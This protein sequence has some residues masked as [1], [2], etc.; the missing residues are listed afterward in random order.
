MRQQLFQAMVQ[1]GFIRKLTTI[2]RELEN[3]VGSKMFGAFFIEAPLM[4]PYD[5]SLPHRR[6]RFIVA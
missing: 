2:A 1:R 4:T 6:V 5:G 3:F